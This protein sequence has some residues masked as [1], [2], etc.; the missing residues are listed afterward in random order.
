M[1]EALSGPPLIGD[2]SVQRLAG[3]DKLDFLDGYLFRI[4]VQM[5]RSDGV[6]K[7]G[8]YDFYETRIKRGGSALSNYDRMLTEYV[9]RRFHGNERRI[10]H[11]GTGLGTLPSALAM[12]GY[13]V[14][15]I[16]Y[17][18]R[19]FQAARRMHEGLAEAW[20][21]KAD[22]Y[23]LIYGEFP[24]AITGTAWMS[25]GAV[26]VFTNCIASW[27][28]ELTARII[29]TLPAW[30]DVLLDT[31]L[32]GTVRETAEE[33]EALLEGFRQQ[34]LLPTPIVE[35]PPGTYYCH[36]KPAPAAR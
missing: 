8:L 31:R 12:A 17:D 10:V 28:E 15:G 35:S 11:A 22:R 5:L 13:A 21:E 24:G 27:S 4:M 16:E 33:R 3:L 26:L 29:G 6:D 34:G 30:G 36:L 9:A 25:S 19:R 7:S 20:P 2:A 18:A 32:F 14:A 23:E 1:L